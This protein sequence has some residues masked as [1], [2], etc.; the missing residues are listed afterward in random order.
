MAAIGPRMK[1]AT[2]Q[3]CRFIKYVAIP[4]N[5]VV[6]VGDGIVGFWA[7]SPAFLLFAAFFAAFAIWVC[8]WLIKAAREL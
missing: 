6:A 7:K 5:V 1:K 4:L 8:P 3:Y 2:E